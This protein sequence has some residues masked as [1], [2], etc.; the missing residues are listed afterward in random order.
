ML[1]PNL[2]W[3]PRQRFE[4][5]DAGSVAAMSTPR[6]SLS[7]YGL[8]GRYPEPGAFPDTYSRLALKALLNEQLGMRNLALSAESECRSTAFI[9][10]GGVKLD[11]RKRSR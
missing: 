9:T 8:N 6:R 7:P 2:N 11:F 4:D 10:M 5:A 1:E 3:L